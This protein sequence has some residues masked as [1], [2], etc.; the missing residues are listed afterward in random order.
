M[1]ATWSISWPASATCRCCWHALR[2][3]K[4]NIN[5]RSPLRGA[6]KC[7]RGLGTKLGSGQQATVAERPKA[8][9]RGPGLKAPNQALSTS[10]R[11]VNFGLV[12]LRGRLRRPNLAVLHS[13]I[14]R[15]GFLGWW[16]P[17]SRT[18]VRRSGAI[19]IF[20]TLSA[21]NVGTVLGAGCAR[22]LQGEARSRRADRPRGRA[23]G[24]VCQPGPVCRSR[25]RQYRETMHG[26]RTRSPRA[27]PAL[28]VN[29]GLGPPPRT[30]QE[31]TRN[32]E[33][34]AFA[35]GLDRS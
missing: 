29:G 32:L 5:L 17:P 3:S 33:P 20:S 31:R 11:A 16:I 10:I 23:Q 35:P 1:R 24:R 30:D 27:A 4:R 34:L 18:S 19:C 8:V 2:H 22:R 25:P 21:R 26:S 14:P 9:N 7:G 12:K 28:R 15:W 6:A 13:K